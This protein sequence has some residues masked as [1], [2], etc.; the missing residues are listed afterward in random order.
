MRA[1]A[2]DL[3]A[4]AVVTRGRE[5]GR[6]L[7]QRDHVRAAAIAVSLDQHD[8][9]AAHGGVNLDARDAEVR[10]A[11]GSS[12]MIERLEKMDIGIPERIVGVEDEIQR[13]RRGG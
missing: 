13:F 11:D 2:L 8:F 12:E 7:M 3:V 5:L 1:D 4:Q 6:R 9:S 10:V